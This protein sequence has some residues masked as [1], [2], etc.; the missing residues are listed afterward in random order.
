MAFGKNSKMILFKT[1][2]FCLFVFS[3]VM[4]IFMTGIVKNSLKKDDNRIS[5]IE[6]WTVTDRSGNSFETGRTYTDRRAYNE[7]FTIVSKL[8]D[9]IRPE[10]ILCFM[11]RSNVRIFIDG[12]IRY[13]FDRQKDTGIPGGSLKEF[14]ITVPLKTSDSGAEL[15]IERG[16][17]DWNPLVCPETFVSTH[18][19]FYT[20]LLCKY[21]ITFA[22]EL[23]LFVTALIVTAIGV[24]LRVIKKHTIDML[25]GALGILDVSLWLLSVSQLTPF[26]T[27]VYYVDGILGF[28]FCMLMPFA[29]LIYINS[30][31]K[32]RYKNCHTVLFIVSFLSFILWTTLHFAQIQSFQKSLVFIDIE[33]AIVVLSV[34]ITIIMDIKKGYIKEYPYSSFGF[35]IFLIMSIIEIV[36]MIFF[37]QYSNELPMLIG[38]MF[39]LIFVVV[40]QIY[41]IR[42]VRDDLEAEINK[43]NIEKAE[44][45]I[46]IVQTLA[47]TIDAKDTYTKGHSGRVADYSKE[48]AKRFGYDDTEQNDIYMMGLL[49]DIGK[50]GISDAIINK[51]GKLTDE[52]YDIMKKHPVLGSKILGNIKEMPELSVGAR[53]H[54]EKYNGKGYPDGIKG[55]EIPEKARII[56]VA[57]AYDAMT[58]YRS[59]RE[60]MPQQKVRQEIEKYSG[61]QFDP[62]F[63]KIMLEM[64]DE[65]KNY[66][67]REK[68]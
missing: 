24:V 11:N 29:L 51:P 43:N 25:Y 19:G 41:D 65:D 26:F 22:M 35:L 62:R 60:P 9:N 20:Y 13:D 21:G 18:E 66:D 38:L 54:H 68:K 44:L 4:G 53:W 52:E 10:S 3:L 67:M 8:P 59:Y 33:L 17:T 31:Q 50:I 56:A 61:T 12:K 39:L 27:R 49:H 23:I 40:Q 1:V 2:F 5:Y 28:L 48:I 64:I 58:S 36:M 32:Q 63:A 55:D 16:K 7:D 57:D 42:K 14:Y 15:R 37:E 47:G 46:H 45:L 34:L 6:S 30:I